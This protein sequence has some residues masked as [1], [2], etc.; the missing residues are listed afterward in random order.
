MKT[1]V[2]TTSHPEAP[3]LAKLEVVSGLAVSL[4]GL[5]TMG[6]EQCITKL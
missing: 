5:R 2:K 1:K 6:R 3:Y 4:E